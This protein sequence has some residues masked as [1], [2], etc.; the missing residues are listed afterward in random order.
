MF[1]LPEEAE[2]ILQSRITIAELQRAKQTC[3][4]VGSM[5]AVVHIESEIRKEERILRQRTSENPDLLRALARNMDME[6]AGAA[7][8]KRLVD[9]ANAQTLS[10]KRLRKQIQDANAKLDLAPRCRSGVRHRG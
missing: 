4:E 1:L 2:W 6:A 5:A 8:R 10:A 3:Q 9:E 7:K